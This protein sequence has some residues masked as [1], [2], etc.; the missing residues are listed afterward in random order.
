MMMATQTREANTQK[1][2]G[3][4]PS[5]RRRD[6]GM[7]RVHSGESDRRGLGDCPDDGDDRDGGVLLSQMI[8]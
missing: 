3:K 5:S 4:I 7:N 8:A 6:Q 2:R 1:D